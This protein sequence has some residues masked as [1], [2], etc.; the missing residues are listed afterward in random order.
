MGGAP[1]AARGPTSPPQGAAAAGEHGEDDPDKDGRHPE[2][3]DP[4]QGRTRLSVHAGAPTPSAVRRPS[5]TRVRKSAPRAAK[6][7]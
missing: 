5:M 3:R 4:E 6:S 1:A 2:R 7:R